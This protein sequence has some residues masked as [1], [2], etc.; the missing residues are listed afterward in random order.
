MDIKLA[1]NRAKLQIKKSSP[2]IM[3][4]G[5]IILNVGAIIW[6]C[7]KT[8]K[9][10]E[11]VNEHDRKIND[12][13][14]TYSEEEKPYKKELT[15]VYLSTAG[16]FAKNYALPAVLEAS[17][18]A[19]MIGSHNVLYGRNLALTAACAAFQDRIK[20]YSK[21]LPK[22]D[23]PQIVESKMKDASEEEKKETI[24]K[25]TSSIYARNFD[26][27]SGNWVPGSMYYNFLFLKNQ[28]NYFNDLLNSRGHVFLNE[29]YDALDVRRNP[30]D[31]STHSKA[32]AVVG[33][34]KGSGGDDFIDFGIDFSCLDKYSIDDFPYDDGGSGIALDFNVDGVI[35]DLI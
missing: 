33:W 29:V 2:E 3:L 34:V 10:K 11:I 27:N 5:G 26:K 16:K 25:T 4:A 31:S 32:G 1:M 24:N 18:M 7:I 9:V 12:V 23:V 22:E 35:Y 15:K 28:Q 21:I 20:D 17:S 8:T 14:A 6:S 30:N 19:L 13:K